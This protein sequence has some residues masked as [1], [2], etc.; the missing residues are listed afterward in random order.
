[1]SALLIGATGQVGRNVLRELLA[2]PHFTR[3][4]EAGRRVTPVEQ[5]KAAGDL[6]KLE[7]KVIDFEKKE[8]LEA[9]LRPGKWDVVFITLGTTRA[10]AGSAEMFEKID[11]EYVLNA[12]KAA[13]STESNQ[14]LVYLVRIHAPTAR[15]PALIAVQSGASSINSSFLLLRSKA[16]TEQGLATL[17]YSDLIVFR[18]GKLQNLNREQP[19]RLEGAIS[20]VT[21]GLS[22]VSDKV[23][24]DVDVLGRSI[25]IAGQRGSDALPAVAEASRTDWG[26]E[27]FTLIGNKG[28]LHLAKES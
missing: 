13:K 24:I 18:P 11:R 22:Y 28:A 20:F 1:M 12:A 23:G 25:R 10:S 9:A 8:E 2:T 4:L 17:G 5:L 16:L 15:L 21:K 3:V 26:G 27:K 7:Q 6:S 14:R 19:H